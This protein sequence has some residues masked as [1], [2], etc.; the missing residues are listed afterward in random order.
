MEHVADCRRPPEDLKNSLD[1][2]RELEVAVCKKFK[3]TYGSNLSKTLLQNG[4]NSLTYIDMAM[5]D[6]KPR[7]IALHRTLKE[8]GEIE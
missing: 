3:G 5:A 1:L 7:L 8:A 2:V 6:P 4:C